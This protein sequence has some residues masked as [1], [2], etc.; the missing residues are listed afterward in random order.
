MLRSRSD[1]EGAGDGQDLARAGPPDA[2]APVD[3]A[4]TSPAAQS[5]DDGLPMPR[6]FWAIVAISFGTAL[7]VVDGAIANVALPTISRE[8]NVNA[9]AVTSVITIYQLVMVM[10]LLPFANLGDR[11][12][13]RKMY[14]LGQLLFC[15]TSALC[16]FA[17]SF[18]LLL[19]L[20]AGQA[21]GAGMALSVAAA[22]IR[23]IYPS[24]SLGTGLGVNA[25]IVAS[26]Y[27][28]APTIGGF[29][30]EHLSWQMVFIVGA[31]LAIIS[32]LLGGALPA[33]APRT[34][35][36]DWLSSI[37]SAATVALVIGGIQIGT[38]GH[39]VAGTVL[40]IFGVVS[41]AFLYHREAGRTAPVVPVD[42]LANKALG[43]TALA[44]FIVFVAS[45]ALTVSLPFRL[46]QGMGYSPEEVGL[47]FAPFPLT[48]LF[49]APA[50]GWLSDRIAPT[51][52]GVVG[53]ALAVA[54]L[55]SLAWMPDPASPLDIG[56]RLVLTALGY[57][58][59]VS[60]NSRLLIGAAPRERSAAAGGLLSTVRLLGQT[61][62]AAIV[63]MMLTLGVGTG[64][65][66]MLFAAVLGVVAALCS[67]A[68]F[69]SSRA[70]GGERAAASL[71]A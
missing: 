54:G 38:H 26:S 42:L 25:V 67:L 7:V 22:L 15:A 48:M 51:K 6:R 41:G 16:F 28:I 35:R 59:F 52:L 10:G 47:L 71:R 45:G 24:K 55:L 8:L 32:L 39:A 21:L 37:W 19:L 36:S 53:M 5:A 3:P 17:T 20:R 62:A 2:S 9:G 69:Q 56:W 34:V 60:P 49:V 18:P 14:Q 27:A 30:T 64:P 57:G 31:P 12:G 23:E 58:L 61:M 11:I 43:F 33:V 29:I 4:G 44:G 50:A 63:G 1:D 65:V 68:R 46:E 66:P 13:L 70:L 40:A